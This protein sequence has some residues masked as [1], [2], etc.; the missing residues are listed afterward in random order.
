MTARPPTGELDARYSDPNAKATTWGEAQ[1]RFA[2]APISWIVTTRPD[3][4][5]HVTPLIS[6]WIDGRPHVT[7]G[8]AE[9]KA[10]NL[11]HDERC[12]IVTG[13]N[14]YD[15][16]IDLVVEGTAARVLDSDI[17]RRVADAFVAK[18]GEQWRFEVG[19]G[20]FLHHDGEAHVF[21]IDPSTAYAFR[22][23]DF[24]HTRFRFGTA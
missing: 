14:T 19:D 11:A 10:R 7:T 13:C 4:R 3:G 17:L 18:Y 1:Q 2:S 5:P 6:V 21:A 15:E 22:K 20:V 9:Q 12:S 8:P 23:G 16:G 24:A